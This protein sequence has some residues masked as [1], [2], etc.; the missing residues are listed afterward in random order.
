MKLGLMQVHPVEPSELRSLGF[1]A[2]QM[3]FKGNQHD[4]ALDLATEQIDETLKAGDSV[5]AART[6]HMGLVGPQGAVA[7]DIERAVRC[8]A[9]TAAL[10][11]RFGDNEKPVLVWHP[12][13]YPEDDATDDQAVHDGLCEGLGAMCSAAEQQDVVVAVE[14]T[15]PGSVGGAEAFLRIKDR[16][17]SEALKVCIDAANFVPDRTPLKR[18]VRMLGPDIAIAHGKDSRFDQSGEAC[19]YGPIG[20]GVLDYQEYIGCLLEYASVP[21]FVLE[22]Y[23]SREDL[24][25]ARDIV[26]QYL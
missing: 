3:F 26:Q 23:Q 20:S 24:L 14:I 2:I 17:G 12:A 13:E 4:D 11:G 25:K 7:A 15:R 21:Y 5:L 22:Y 19:H 8:V 6:L 16:V 9:K 1:E 18:A 10:K